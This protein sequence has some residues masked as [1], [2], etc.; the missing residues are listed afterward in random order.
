MERK[1][2]VRL[3]TV[4]NGRR[5][6]VTVPVAV[7]AAAGLV[8]AGVSAV[9]ATTVAGPAGGAPSG[10][11]AAF[12]IDS[13]W[14]TGYSGHYTLTNGTG[15][16]RHG[17]RLE[18]DLPAGARITSLWEGSAA[19][20]TGHVV[21]S[22]ARW[23]ADLAG[24]A[25]LTVGFVV[26][27]PSG[28]SS[29]PGGCRIDGLPCTGSS[30]VVAPTAAPTPTGPTTS[31]TPSGPAT[32]GPGS[33]APRPTAPPPSSSPSSSPGSGDRTTPGTP[34]GPTAPATSGPPATVPAGAPGR[35]APYVDT[36]LHPPFDLL[37]AA[38]SSGV[39]TYT[40]AFVI[41]GGGCTPKWGGVSGLDADPVAAQIPRLRA[42]GGDVRVSFGGAAGSELALACP[43]VTSLAAAYRQ[44]IAHY[45]LTDVDFDVEGAAT[46]DAA[47]NA[48]RAQALALLQR[49][50]R[51]AGRTLR[52]SLTLP[53]LPSG[54]TPDGLAVVRATAGAGVDLAAVNVMA[55][56]FGD[57]AAP[58]PSGRMGRYAIDAAT[59]TQKQVAAA[60]GLDPAAAWA[61]IAVTPMIGVNDVAT[62][63]FTV[64]DARQLASF[65]GTVHLAWL[66]FWSSGRDRACPNG[67]QPWASPVCSGIAQQ[68]GEFARAFGAFAG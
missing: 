51:A 58:D 49:E 48:R 42:A 59:A 1:R 64:A 41:S 10:L 39:R 18:F 17:W 57:G 62:E 4:G 28:R 22:P 23:N 33:P 30:P 6:R 29:L 40:L 3:R 35:V 43:D 36:S 7:T 67:P 46:A 45:A 60:L 47:A 8:V 38:R 16:T 24:G 26:T 63:V 44:V 31:P 32:H 68:P 9:S 27:Q 2:A 34:D 5:G 56:D 25:S 61:R 66:A 12:G 50:A 53:V 65:A 13:R 19:G 11:S 55:M 54:L 20:T 14:D 21:V 52:V 37:A 15:G